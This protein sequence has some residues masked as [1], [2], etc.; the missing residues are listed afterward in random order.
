MTTKPI[1]QASFRVDNKLL[2]EV[3]HMRLSEYSALSLTQYVVYLIGIGRN[4]LLN[5]NQYLTS[6]YFLKIKNNFYEQ[7]SKITTQSS[8]RIQYRTESEW[9]NDL[10]TEEINLCI[11][12]AI[13]K[14]R[15]AE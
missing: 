8:K 2:D 11:F 14:E 15:K 6:I 10:S 5:A 12:M 4:L 9:L 3:E 13:Q 1:I 7:Y